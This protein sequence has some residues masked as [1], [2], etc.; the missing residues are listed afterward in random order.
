M[1]VLL[2]LVDNTDAVLFD[3]ND[4][5]GTVN[6]GGLK[7]FCFDV[8][9]G[10]PSGSPEFFNPSAYAGGVL[11]DQRDELVTM[12][13]KQG[14]SGAASVDAFRSAVGAM[15]EAMRSGGILKYRPIAGADTRYIDFVSSQ[16][17]AMLRGQSIGPVKLFSQLHDPDGLPIS[18]MRQPYL[19]G[20]EVS[21]SPVTVSMDP[22][23][24]AFQIVDD[25]NRTNATGWGTAQVGGSWSVTQGTASNVA[26]TPA[27]ATHTHTAAGQTRE[28]VIGSVQNFDA[29]FAFEPFSGGVAGG[30]HE[31]FVVFRRQDANN[32]YRLRIVR[33]P[34]PEP[35]DS[36]VGLEKVVGGVVSTVVA[37]TTAPVG[38]ATSATPKISARLYVSGTT[39]Q[40]K[41]WR[42]EV[43]PAAW[44]ISTTDSSISA[45]GGFGFRTYTDPAAT[46][47]S[48]VFSFYDLAV[49][50]VSAS[51]G[52]RETAVS[53][54]TE[55]P[56]PVK[57]A[58]TG[59]T[60][61]K[62]QGVLIAS[63]PGT[64]STARRVTL[65]TGTLGTSVRVRSSSEAAT[66]AVAQFVYDNPTNSHS[67]QRRV[68]KTV[69]TGVDDL[70][71]DWD[72]FIR[73]R[74]N[75]LGAASRFKSYVQLK[76][77]AT[78]AEPAPFTESE[79]TLDS[80]GFATDQASFP[81]VEINLG[82][83]R[84][85]ESGSLTGVAFEIWGRFETN[86]SSTDVAMEFGE[87]FLVP[88][89]TQ[90]FVVIPSIGTTYVFG[91]ATTGSG[92]TVDG[93]TAV[94]DASGDYSEY[95][96]GAPVAGRWRAT[97]RYSTQNATGSPAFQIRSGSTV[98]ASAGLDIG[99]NENRVE[100]LEWDADG[101]TSYQ[102]R[103]TGP[104]AGS[105]HNHELTYSFIPVL[106]ANEELR[107][108]PTDLA[109]I[110]AEKLDSADNHVVYAQ[111]SGAMPLT[112]EDGDHVLYVAAFDPRR[113]GV[114][115]QLESSIE[116]TL[117]VVCSYSP[118]YRG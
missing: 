52:G 1:T 117:S 54:S 101:T 39:I 42:N 114:T 9:L 6:A 59:T 96:V 61:G 44:D 48:E 112:L 36:T 12:S 92:I 62:T 77:G 99:D 49:R 50:S 60:G 33:P 105:V 89:A 43:E 22:S 109:F 108:D 8:D 110:H 72:V 75:T 104:T 58:L 71:G 34:G 24:Y 46:G 14:F 37:Q 35:T 13:W 97:A 87:L 56:T 16:V 113:E 95:S 23:G 66:G 10:S 40:A 17:G 111:S 38:G 83:I 85:P 45:A 41:I 15:A 2:Q 20:A 5:T 106:G 88:T 86:V 70:R 32:Y 98:I 79:Q 68:R 78:T 80:T 76:W 63:A 51:Y 30:P 84:I 26:V 82:R 102:L 7:T 47:F 57:V 116:R 27:K 53:I 90:G 18:V 73:V 67:T 11:V 28:T 91:N 25:F 55:A 74:Q 64:A 3:F 4:R 65:S 69:T 19:R 100:A 115:P 21:T 29:V 118:R 93:T 107:T 31:T 81:W 94:L 103:V